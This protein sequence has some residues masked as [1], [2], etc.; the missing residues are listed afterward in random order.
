MLHLLI[1]IWMSRSSLIF[2]TT[3][4]ERSCLLHH[5]IMFCIMTHSHGQLIRHCC[6]PYGWSCVANCGHFD[7]T[8]VLFTRFAGKTLTFLWFTKW[9]PND[10]CSN[11]NLEL[12]IL[13]PCWKSTG[14][15]SMDCPFNSNPLYWFC[16]IVAWTFIHAG[17]IYIRLVSICTTHGFN[18]CLWDY[19]ASW[20]LYYQTL[21][22][23]RA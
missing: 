1:C 8:R 19:L 13:K 20:L 7:A 21:C 18:P 4:L 6:L 12:S 10:L 11:R 15:Q 23:H 17:N 5:S 16:F 3:I 9:K 2:H 14:N 22:L